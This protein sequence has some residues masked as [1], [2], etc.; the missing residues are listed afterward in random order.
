MR[1]GWKERKIEND[2]EGSKERKRMIESAK[3]RKRE[4]KLY[5]GR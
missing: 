5:R 1:N 4:R 2:R 3:E